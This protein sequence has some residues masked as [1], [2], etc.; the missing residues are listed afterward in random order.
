M[1]YFLYERN[2]RRRKMKRFIS[3]VYIT[4][5]VSTLLFAQGN[6]ESSQ[7]S[8]TS[9]FFD[10]TV[11]IIIPYGAG[12]THDVVARKFAEVGSKYTKEPI[13]CV[14]ETGGDGLVAAIH[15]TGKDPNV[16]ELLT[17]SYGLWYQKIVKGDSVKLDLSKINPIGTFDDRSYLLYVRSDS[18]Y[19][20]LEDLIAESKT[21]KVI[22]SAGAAGA[23]A[24][25]CFGGLIQQAGGDSVIASYEGGAQQMAALLN[26]EVDCFVGTPQ[27]GKQYLENGEVRAL[28]CFKDFDFT[29]FK[30]SLGIIVP[31]VADAG[32]PQSAITGGGMLSLRTGAKASY[33][34]DV[35]ELI[36]KVWADPEFRNFTTSIGLNIFECYGS[37]LDKHIEEAATNA[38]IS[39]KALNL[40]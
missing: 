14:Q 21:R 20:T 13:V 37:D 22:L 35:E 28:I 6:N 12:G 24:H 38:T 29:G 34:K 7:V 5:L 39:A 33:E 25:L 2:K 17:T 18:K 27:V 23:D 3:L 26:G 8:D 31:N 36:K 19:Q 1:V 10:E 16:R 40:I 32:Y 30:D 15:F 4:L 11:K 9:N